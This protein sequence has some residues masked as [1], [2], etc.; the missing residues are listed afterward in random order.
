M[1]PFSEPG[2]IIAAVVKVIEISESK[3]V[4]PT[5]VLN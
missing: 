1:I 2:L 3:E 4:I 5:D